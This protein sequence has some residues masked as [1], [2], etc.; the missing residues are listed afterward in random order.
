MSWDSLLFH[1][2][3]NGGEVPSTV[4]AEPAGNIFREAVNHDEGMRMSLYVGDFVSHPL[5]NVG[6]RKF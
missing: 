1:Y 4:K 2:F 6:K 3:V 5:G